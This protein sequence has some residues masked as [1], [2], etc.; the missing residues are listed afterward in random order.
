MIPARKMVTRSSSMAGLIASSSRGLAIGQPNM[1]DGQFNSLHIGQ[2]TEENR[3]ERKREDEFDSLSGS[4]NGPEGGSDVDDDPEDSNGRKNKKKRRYHRHT[5][6]QIQT[7]EAFFKECPHPDD[8]QRRE[9][10]LDLGLKPLQIKFWF[11]NKRTQLK[12]QHERHE[13]SQ[14][15]LEN[16]RLRIDNMRYKE[17]LNNAACP[18][19]GGPTA[20]AELSFEEHQ[21]R[22]ENS[23]LRDE[24]EKIAAMAAQY[25][26]KPM[27]NFTMDSPPVN[28]Q[29][30]GGELPY[31]AGDI[32][33]STGGPT[34][35]QVDKQLILELAG[36]AMDELIRMARIGEPLW[37]PGIDN[38]S[39]GFVLNEEE[40]F[41]AF[42]GCFGRRLPA[43]KSEASRAIGIVMMSPSN[44]AEILMDVN[45]WSA[46]FAEIVARA[47]ILEVLSTRVGGNCDG[48]MQVMSAEF[49]VLSPVVPTRET[50]FVR[51]CKHHG[52]GSWAVVDFSPDSLHP[53]ALA[54]CRR[55]PSGC[56]IQEMPNGYSK[57]T[58]V[59]H[60][61]VDD[62]GTLN[63]YR[64]LV[65][66]GLAFGAK[67]WT[68]TLERQ[69]ERF[70]SAMATNVPPNDL[71]DTGGRRNMLKLAER[72]VISFCGGVGAST[73]QTW[74]ALSGS[75]ADD[76]R[77][78]TQ[79][80]VN[81]PGRPSG[82]VISAATSFWLP[83]A[84]KRVFGFLRNE[85]FRTEWDILCNG[86][87]VEEIAHVSNGREIGNCVSLIRVN[88]V[89]G[90]QSNML[91]IQE[92][93]CDPTG[94]FVVYAPV[95]VQAIEMVLGGGDPDY[96]ALLPS[97]FSI[98]PD[99][100]P[101]QQGGGTGGA[102]GSGGTLITAA[103]QILVDSA[104]DAKLALGTVTT[105]N[106]L[107][108]CTVERLK[109]A[110][111]SRLA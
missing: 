40:Y 24:V 56:L 33:R 106:N 17:A 51:Y 89:D 76:V 99:G 50:P 55:R 108:A 6:H 9:L 2:G 3:V 86:G 60:V 10:G 63:I 77:V 49:Q 81:N 31:G 65:N 53:A 1:M 97:G 20:L 39:C 67:R 26:G 23:R 44:L 4:E 57:V 78:M 75:G 74:T 16:E 68:S 96:V 66:S 79:K 22:I 73:A 43:L 82:V 29:G 70:A 85:S 54:R 12:M 38:S 105:V 18:A 28:E 41:R 72:M 101:N 36:V 19:C 21:L 98:L 46:V 90:D 95:D 35:Y 84:P 103:F 88:G 107:I 48:S 93:C 7:M 62:S 5:Q 59:E 61:E 11:Q 32:F 15:R 104:P 111:G 102:G 92:S 14:L 110:V 64:P 13:N 71:S 25:T 94:S 37:V 100:P 47:M 42:S 87:V 80:S 52:D 27:L 109:A 45:Q 30:V 91:I 83:V 58:W 34:G 69:C 8:K